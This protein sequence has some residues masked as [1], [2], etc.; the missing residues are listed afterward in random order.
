VEGISAE[1]YFETV[2]SVDEIVVSLEVGK[3]MVDRVGYER[4]LDFF[5]RAGFLQLKQVC[6]VIVD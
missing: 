5:S 4:D 3:V 2:V 1:H 6:E